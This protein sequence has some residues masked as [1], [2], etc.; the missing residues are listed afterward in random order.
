MKV[1]DG[2]FF[3]P[4]EGFLST[5]KFC[6]FLYPP[7]LI[8]LANLLDNLLQL[9]HQHLLH[10]YIME[11][12]S[13]TSWTNLCWLQ[14]FFLQL[15]HLSQSSKYWRELGPCSRLVSG[16]RDCYDWLNF[17]SRPL[18]LFTSVKK[19]FAFLSLVCST[20]VALWMPSRLFLC[21]YNFANYN[22]VQEAY[23]SPYL[24][25]HYAFLTKLNHF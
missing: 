17:L 13:Y 8:I 25:F 6:Y 20:G 2:I 5:L 11:V 14:T 15:R 3:F 23:L 12:A 24:G 19:P 4:I 9:L 22:L 18:K 1:L 21:I 7:S 10:F 16:L